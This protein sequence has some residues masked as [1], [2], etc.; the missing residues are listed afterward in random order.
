M[1]ILRSLAFNFAFYANTIV[2]M[3]LW[4]P[5]YFLAPRPKAWFIPKFWARS[6]IW[7][8]G[9]IA[10]TK[11]RYEGLENLPDGPFILAPKH[12]ST[13]DTLAL[14]P[15]L[16]DPVYILK[17]ELMWIPLFGWYVGKMKMI[18]IDRGARSVALKKAM[19]ISR[20]RMADGRQLIIYPEGTRR[21]SGAE[22]VYKWGIVEIYSQLGVP[23]VPVVHHAGLFWPRRRFH[24]YPGT[25]VARFLPPIEPGL[26]KQEFLDRLIAETEAA[27]DKLLI[28]TATG[29]DAP[30]LP[31]TARKRLVELGVD[32]SGMKSV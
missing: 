15:F 18:P 31:E 21:P 30:P 11:S 23:V 22:P 9:A 29:P 32:V 8:L 1:L 17:R 3:I 10:G 13:W 20:E 12:Q 26:G 27:S 14:F 25:L 5:Y 2:Q 6:N 7:L 16:K 19:A 4:T 24:K 28:E